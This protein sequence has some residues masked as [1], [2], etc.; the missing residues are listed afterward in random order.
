[1]AE[2]I[3]Q[4]EDDIEEEQA[5][6]ARQMTDDLIV[7]TGDSDRPEDPDEHI[8]AG[9]EASGW[10]E[11][12]A[13]LSL[14]TVHTGNRPTDAELLSS[15]IAEGGTI[16]KEE[17]IVR[18]REEAGERPDGADSRNFGLE[19]SGRA[20]GE[21][22]AGQEFAQQPAAAE[23]GG[24]TYDIDVT[25]ALGGADGSENLSVTIGNVPGGVAFSSGA[26]NGDGS[27]TFESGDLGDL[28]MTVSDGTDAFDLTVSAIAGEN[29]G[30]AAAATA[31]ISVAATG[32]GADAACLDVSG[33][34]DGRV[35]DS[36][37]DDLFIFG[38]GDGADYFRGGDGWSET[39]RLDG[40]DG[41]ELI[42]DGAE[43]LEW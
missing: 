21:T 7:S 9:G 6:E 1:M 38:A 32:A 14:S 11:P 39:V 29:D 24:V 4:G 36:Q 37:G 31:I 2:D 3:N 23:A 26:D 19:T 27:W 40:A 35:A 16:I 20:P 25:A 17:D 22:G 43:K 34:G 12:S 18:A 28:A 15:L 30:G 42:F 8:D 41:G 5:A 33:A 10:S 13:T